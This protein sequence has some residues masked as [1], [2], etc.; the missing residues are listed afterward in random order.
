MSI[1]KE[2]KSQLQT[3]Q[4]SLVILS[5]DDL[6][7]I[8]YEILHEYQESHKTNPADEYLSSKEVCQLLHIS[9]RTF[10]RYRDRRIIPFHQRG[11]FITVKRSDL[12]AFQNQCLIETRYS[13]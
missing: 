3:L 9:P 13:K 4:D 5:V 8:M 10:Q 7:T 12:E 11:R 2:T 1:T 6:R